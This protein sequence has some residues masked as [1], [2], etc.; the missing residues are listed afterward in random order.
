MLSQAG[1]G[2]PTR[3]V[4][5]GSLRPRRWRRWVL[6]GTAL[7][8]VLVFVAVGSYVGLSAAPALALPPAT[9]AP[10]GEVEG[11]W[12]VGAGSVAGFRIQQTVLGM[13][14]DVVGWTSGVSGT[15][16]VSDDR[17]ISAKFRIDLTAIT[18]DGKTPPQLALSLDTEHH[19]HATIT[20][21][22]PVALSSAF[23]AGDTV[24]ATATGELAMH[25]VS[26]PVTIRF[27]GRRDG[28][29]L[30]AVGSIPVA[31]SDWDIE[32]PEGYG[33]LGSLAVGGIAE[34]VVILHRSDGA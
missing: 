12:Q 9:A 30:Q 8:V 33:F 21:A 3:L 23:A 26:H 4:S 14:G 25:G 18:V 29:T 24:A 15:V 5:G 10:T 28:S 7:V 17:I 11:S 34:F 27:S 32:G 20:L 2:V 13:T 31:F 1:P 19:P 22:E 6:A 16:L